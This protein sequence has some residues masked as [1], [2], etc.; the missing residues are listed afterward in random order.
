MPVHQEEQRTIVI[1]CQQY[2]V[3]TPGLPFLMRI[4]VWR[5]PTLL[6]VTSSLKVAC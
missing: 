1:K 2:P 4:S 6:H 3:N 5:R